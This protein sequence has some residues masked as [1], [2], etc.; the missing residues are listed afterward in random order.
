MTPEIIFQDLR[1]DLP[2]PPVIKT[3]QRSV[4]IGF[5]R[6]QSKSFQPLPPRTQIVKTLAA[7]STVS[8]RMVIIK[9]PPSHA[10]VYQM[11]A[12]EQEL[13]GL[14]RQELVELARKAKGSMKEAK[15]NAVEIVRQL[16]EEW[17]T[18]ND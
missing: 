9:L 10:R 14:P 3:G 12:I 16:R 1:L 6:E 13:K 8:W 11:L 15:N 2:F 17:G 4:N 7:A 5:T 18:H